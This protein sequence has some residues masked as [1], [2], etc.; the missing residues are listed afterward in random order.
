MGRPSLHKDLVCMQMS[1]L[2]WRGGLVIIFLYINYHT[3]FLEW[4]SDKT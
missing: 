3:I 4:G 1:H 2:L